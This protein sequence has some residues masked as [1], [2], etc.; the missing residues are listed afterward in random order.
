MSLVYENEVR[1]VKTCFRMESRG[2]MIDPSYVMKALEHERQQISRA[3]EDFAANTGRAYKD[4]PK[5]FKAIFTERGIAYP[6]T[7]KGN[8]SFNSEAL[9]ENGSELAGLILKIRE[10]EKRA[11]TYY[12]AFL[13]YADQNDVIH[14]NIRQAGTTTGR[15]SYSNPNLQNVPKEDEEG[16]L[17]KEF[18]VRGSFIPRPGYVLM[19]CDYTQ[20]EYMLMLDYAG[21]LPLIKMVNEGA[22]LHQATADMVGITRKR[23]KTLNFAILYGAG[24]K[25]LAK[26][27][28]LTEEEAR[29]LRQEYF[30]KLPKISR[31]IKQVMEVGEKRGF[32][33]NWLD[34]QCRIDYKEEAYK[35]PNHLIQ[36]GAGDVMKVAMNRIDDLLLDKRSGM[37]IQIHD[38]ILWE[39]HEEE[40]DLV[41]Q[42]KD[43]MEKVYTP[44]NGVYLKAVP[45]I[46]RTSWAYR[47]FKKYVC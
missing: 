7:E 6:L 42:V 38:D 35:L 26:M 14:P 43:I 28:D 33:R 40:M 22:D 1:L 44:K 25:K 45:E 47:D 23:A 31:F 37:L 21:E 46:S 10:H 36:G 19:S 11:G 41:P 39:C 13:H 24:I 15:M 5:L 12:S 2:I 20:V 16:D 29:I 27:L 8:P 4:S 9:E 3:K 18:V 30:G 32:V 34:R 17:K